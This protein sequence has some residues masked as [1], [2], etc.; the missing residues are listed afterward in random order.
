MNILL[1]YTGGRKTTGNFCIWI[2][3]LKLVSLKSGRNRLST[4]KCLFSDHK[5]KMNVNISY[6]GEKKELIDANKLLT[7]LLL[8]EN[9][10]SHEKG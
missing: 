9:K 3:F 10:M 5:E 2:L 8:M 6:H 1:G 7:V 4:P